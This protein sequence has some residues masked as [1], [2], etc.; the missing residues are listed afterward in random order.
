MLGATYL[1]TPD[2]EPGQALEVNDLRR[3][4]ADMEGVLGTRPNAGLRARVDEL[5]RSLGTLAETQAKLARDTKA[6]E[7]KVGGGQEIP[8]ELLGR[9]TRAEAG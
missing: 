8:Q 4:V 6:L 5:G 7:T 9:L 1:L 3:R 2:R